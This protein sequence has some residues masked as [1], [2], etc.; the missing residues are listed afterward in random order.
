MGQIHHNLA[1]DIATF[2]VVDF[3]RVGDPNR[4]SSHGHRT[5]WTERL[6]IVLH[7]QKVDRTNDAFHRDTVKKSVRW[8]INGTHFTASDTL[9]FGTACFFH[10][11]GNNA[12]SRADLS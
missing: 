12:K 1:K 3:P 9:A 6:E 5:K 2:K 8:S 4:E 10:Q 7:G 11:L